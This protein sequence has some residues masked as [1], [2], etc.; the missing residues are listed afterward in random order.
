LFFLLFTKKYKNMLILLFKILQHKKVIDINLKYNIIYSKIKLDS[1]IIINYKIAYIYILI[2]NIIYLHHCNKKC[3]NS[4]KCINIFSNILYYKIYSFNSNIFK[5][6]KITILRLILTWI[7]SKKN[8]QN[9]I[10]P[11]SNDKKFAHW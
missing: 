1:S 6:A 2:Y 3:L 11:T 7:V 5:Y 8:I 10:I 9:N 4:I